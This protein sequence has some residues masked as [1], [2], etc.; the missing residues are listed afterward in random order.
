MKKYIIDTNLFFNMEA[1][2]KLGKKTEEVIN[3]IT[4]SARKLLETGK[5]EIIMPPRI[6]E[7]FLSFFEDKEQTI[8][9]QLLGVITVKSPELSRISFSVDLFYQLVDDIR[10]RNYRGLNLGEELITKAGKLMN[11]QKSSS[12]KEFQIQIGSV[13]RSYRDRY[14]QITRF[15]FIDSLGD[16]DLIVLAQEQEGFLVSTDE[17]VIKWGRKFG[18]REISASVFGEEM[19]RLIEEKP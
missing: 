16:L 4:F 15:G 18:V 8:I 9:K 7:E 2:L 14:R 5:G 1:G 19:R 17:G 6:V 11:D 13:I 3:N 12:I 10:I